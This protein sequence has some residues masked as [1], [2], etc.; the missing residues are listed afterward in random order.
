MT[1]GGN[2]CAVSQRNLLLHLALCVLLDLLDPVSA[3]LTA[4][5][6]ALL[7]VIV[8]FVSGALL[9]LCLIVVGALLTVVAEE[10]QLAVP[11]ALLVPYDLT[12]LYT[13][14]SIML[15]GHLH[16]VVL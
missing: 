4:R 13:L 9:I 10:L 14:L 3:E 6:A 11:P 7:I 16:Q 2:L 1:A 15:F 12:A 8:L 5:V